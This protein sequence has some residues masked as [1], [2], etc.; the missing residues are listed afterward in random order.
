[1][2]DQERHQLPHEGIP[3]VLAASGH[4][5][6]VAEDVPR[7]RRVVCGLLR[8]MSRRMESTPLLLLSGLAEG[9]DQLVADAALECGACLAVVLPLPKDLYRSRMALQAQAEFERLL[10]RAS[11]VIDLPLACS[12]DELGESEEARVRQY[13]A[14]AD[15]LAFHCQALIAL[16]DGADSDSHGGTFEVVRSVLAGVEHEDVMEPLR[17][18]V[19]HIVTPR[20]RHTAPLGGAFELRAMRCPGELDETSH[21][22]PGQSRGRNRKR[23]GKDEDWEK[24]SLKSADL[25][26]WR[27][28]PR[29]RWWKLAARR[30]DPRREPAIAGW[31]E[32]LWMKLVEP[33]PTE[34]DLNR[35]NRAVAK[36]GP[37]CVS[38]IRLQPEDWK[39]RP[40]PYLNRIEDCHRRADAVAK[41][42]QRWRDCWLV[43]ILVAALLAAIGLETHTQLYPNLDPLW[44][45]FPSAILA[46]FALH[47]VAKRIDIENRFLDARMLAEA[48]RVQYFWE[49]GGVREPVW[50]HYL[51]HRPSELGWVV[52]ALRGLSLFRYE[53]P[54]P[55]P[56][57]THD[58]EAALRGWVK[59]QENYYERKSLK[60]RKWLKRLETGSSGVLLGVVIVCSV[61]AAILL[62][63]F[64]GLEPWKERVHR[65]HDW[66]HWS[67]AAVSVAMGLVKVWLE[68]AGYDEQAR[69]YRR[70]GHLFAHRRERLAK[71]LH[72][73][74][75]PDATRVADAVRVLHDLGAKALEEHSIWLIMHREHPLT[76]KGGG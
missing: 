51:A 34:A 41:S 64:A 74:G 28:E 37:D 53:Q 67:I 21:A 54:G 12:V 26:G 46:A 2:N 13:C 31:R 49:M 76:V 23:A 40:W 3:F 15:F 35:F 24:A 59:D 30:S 17:G 22:V 5:D 71:V 58:V 69:N 72:A 42:S 62:T 56:A 27:L 4:R 70:M 68:Q 29:Q 38:A 47:W 55:A 18:T 33:S 19:Y 57:T 75:T 25:N 14:L 39:N 7:L 6:L 65:W 8:R 20:Q 50:E 1:M 16:W 45:A 63:Q 61:I 73:K 9:A 43:G 60:Q 66:I 44:L 11:L 48:L 52:S 10:G 36:L 32:R